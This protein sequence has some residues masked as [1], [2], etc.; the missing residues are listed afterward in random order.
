LPCYPRGRFAAQRDARAQGHRRG[1][2]LGRA[3]IW[4]V[5]KCGGR[6]ALRGI[7]DP[8]DNPHDH[9]LA[10]VIARERLRR[11]PVCTVKDFL[12]SRDPDLLAIRVFRQAR[13]FRK[14]IRRM[15]LRNRPDFRS[16]LVWRPRRPAPELPVFPRA[17]RPR[18][19]QLT[20]FAPMGFISVFYFRRR[21]ACPVRAG[22]RPPCRCLASVRPPCREDS[23]PVTTK[24]IRSMSTSGRPWRNALAASRDF[25]STTT[26]RREPARAL[27]SSRAS[28]EAICPL[29]PLVPLRAFSRE[30]RVASLRGLG[31]CTRPR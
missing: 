28:R 23:T 1:R 29:T 8:G 26:I 20:Y 7:S 25:L 6:R 18:H 19:F 24:V 17:F 12:D 3:F 14:S 16:Y 27:C 9:R 4:R 2:G 15:P 10:L 13:Q 30:L 5:S 11:L 21:T 22:D 31:H